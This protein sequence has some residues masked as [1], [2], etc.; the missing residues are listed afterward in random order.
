MTTDELV[1][2]STL[3]GVVFLVAGIGMCLYRIVRGP[4]LADRGVAADTMGV[5]LLGLVI[6]LTIRWGE[7]LFVDGMLVI[8]LLSFAGT[9]AIAQFIARPYLQPQDEQR[10]GSS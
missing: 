3:L 2:W 7:L 5:Q 10:E 9:V 8:A 1:E 4:T 6:V